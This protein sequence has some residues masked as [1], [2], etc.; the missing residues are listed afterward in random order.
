M[1]HQSFFY[2]LSGG[3][4]SGSVV[5]KNTIRKSHQRCIVV[6]G[7]NNLVVEDNV[8]F[9]SFGHCFIMEDG[10]ETGNFFLRNLGAQIDAPVTLIANNGPETDNENAIFWFTNP[11]NYV[12][13]NVAAGSSSGTGIWFELKKRGPLKDFYPDPIYEPLGSFINNVAHSNTGRLGAVRL[14]PTG[15]LPN[16]STESIFTGLKVYRNTG[17]GIFIHKVQ[18]FGLTGSIF[19]DNDKSIDLDR[20]EAIEVSDTTIIGMSESYSALMARETSTGKICSAQGRASG[21][22]LHS[23]RLRNVEGA[24]SV[25]NVDIRGFGELDCRD[26]SAIQMDPF[27]LK[28]GGFEVYT[29]FSSMLVED[30]ASFVDFCFAEAGGVNSVYLMD[31]DGSLAPSSIS[32]SGPCALISNNPKMTS[33]VDAAACT[34]MEEGCYQYCRE[35]CFNSIRYTVDTTNSKDFEL[36][37]CQRANPSSCIKMQWSKRENPADPFGDDPR[38]FLVHLPSGNYD[39]AFVDGLG[40]VVWPTFV[41]RYDELALCS[42]SV[43]VAMV[44]P[45]IPTTHCSELI[46]NGNADASSTEPIAW[47]T[48][49]GGLKVAQGSGVGNSNAFTG[50]KFDSA[51]ILQYLDTRCLTEGTTYKV[52]GK[53]RLE[54]STGNVSVCNPSTDPLCPSVGLFV[55]GSGDRAITS[56]SLKI[57]ANGYQFVEGTFKVDATIANSDRVNIFVDWIERKSTSVKRRVLVDDFSV[58]LVDGD[59]SGEFVVAPVSAPVPLPSDSPTTAPSA[60]PTGLPSATPTGVP[61]T[62]RPSGGP[63]K[64]PSA[65][66]TGKQTSTHCCAHFHPFPA[67]N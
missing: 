16:G 25:K 59:P 4:V 36:K 29:S 20:S 53:V 30:G 3:D 27:S 14:Y 39:A 19:S 46:R 51:K 2:T 62:D 7:S 1:S 9:D 18:Y 28:Q 32:T 50:S 67:F 8:A 57:D 23:W 10:I 33:F 22:E 15:F 34:M 45:T 31:L 52:T 48:A 35:T 65:N 12:E 44:T 42:A 11:N 63:T 26:P 13:G 17:T 43:D 64:A 56:L 47:L 40:N 38:T 49:S 61:S 6:H 55:E 41:E 24:V 21:I 37:V 60:D 66:P 54:D 5:R 58:V